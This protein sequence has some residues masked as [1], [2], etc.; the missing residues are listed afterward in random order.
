MLSH[1]IEFP[2]FDYLENYQTYGINAVVIKY[3]RNIS[4]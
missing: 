2:L 3:L 4:L 1:S